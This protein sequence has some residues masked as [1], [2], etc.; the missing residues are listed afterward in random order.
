MV[1]IF[2]QI[3]V[4][5]R[6]SIVVWISLIPIVVLILRLLNWWLEEVWYVK[7]FVIIVSKQGIVM[8]NFVLLVVLKHVIEEDVEQRVDSPTC[9]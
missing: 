3:E 7:P 4:L 9:E 2:I 6:Q 5:R 1:N 8:S